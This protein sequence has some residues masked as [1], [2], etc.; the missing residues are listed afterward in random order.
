MKIIAIYLTISFA[1]GSF[2]FAQAPVANFSAD[3]TSG[4]SPFKVNFFDQ[5][6]GNPTSWQWD[7]GNGTI[8][9]KKDPSGVYLNPGT[10]QVK[11]TVTN[12]SGSSSKTGSITVYENPKAKFTADKKIGCAPLTVQFTDLSEA[13]NNSTNSKWMWDFGNGVQSELQNP[14]VKYTSTGTFTVVLKVTND[15]GC[16]NVF[17]EEKLIQVNQGVTLG[18]TNS[19]VATCQPPFNIQFTNS[20]TGAGT[21]NYTWKFGDGT[22][23]PDISPLHTYTAVGNYSVSLIGINNSGCTDT[24]TKEIKLAESNTDFTVSDTLCVNNAIFFTNNSSPAPTSSLWK[25]PDGTTATSVNAQKIFTDA[26]MYTIK[27]S[28][29]YSGCVGIK[30]KT[31]IVEEAPKAFFTASSLGK[32]SPDLTVTFDNLSTNAVKYSW[33]FGDGSAPEIT[34]SKTVSHTYTSLGF[35]KVTLTAFNNS[36]CSNTYILPD[37]IVIGP[38]IA[39]ITNVPEQACAP[40]GINPAA[41]ISS[42][43]INS[44]QWNFG[45]GTI[46][47]EKSPSHNYT[48]AGNYTITVSATTNDGC[49]VTDTTTI[50]VGNHSTLAFTANPRNVCAI[51]SVYFTNQSQPENALFTWY[52]G[53]GGTSQK[54]S[55]VYTYNDTGWFQVKL[56]ANNNGCLDS[57]YSEEK[58]IYIKAPIARFSYTP[59][60]NISYQYQFKDESLFDIG[61]EGNRTWKWVFPDGSIS[62]NPVPPVYTFPGPGE[63]T[64]SLT[65]SNGNCIHTKKQ[66]IRIVNKAADFSY[67]TNKKCK[68]VDLSFTAISENLAN[69]ESFRWEINGFD[70]TT[71]TPVFTHLFSDAG[72]YD[73]KLTTTDVTGCVDS[74]RKPV[75][76]S[77][78]EAAFSRTHLDDCTK[79]T[80]T[81]TDESKSFGANKI[82]SWKWDFGD[83]KSIERTNADTIK[84]TYDAPGEYL[85]KLLIRD[86]TGCMDTVQSTDPVIIKELSADWSAD[87]KACL[88]FPISFKNTSVGEFTSA[89]W[90]F[91][92][93]SPGTSTPEG[94]HTYTD[95]GRYDLKLVIQNEMGCKDSLVRKQ[96]V[97]IAKPLAAFSV[98]DSISFCPPFDVAFTNTSDFFKEV[99]WEIGTE[100][101]NEINH[102]KLFTQPGEYEVMLTVKSPDNNCTATASKTIKV[103]RSEDALI[104]YDPEQACLPGLVNFSAF[105]KLASARFFWDFGD[106]NILD[107]AANKITHLY[108]DLGSFTPK[109]ILTE[110]NGCVITIAGIKPIL[111]KGAKAKFSVSNQFFCDS[112]YVSIA[113]STTY[114]EPIA[115]YTWNFGDGTTSNLQTPPPH[116]FDRPGNYAVNLTVETTSGCKDTAQLETP[117]KLVNS[118]RIGIAGDS[119]I[120]VN[121]KIRHTGTLLEEDPSVEWFW[122]FPNGKNEKAQKPPVQ[123]YKEAGNFIVKTIAV[124]GSGCADTATKKIYV[125]PN[126]KATLPSSVSTTVGTPVL[127]PGKYTPQPVSYIWS[128]DSSLSCNN[129]PQPMA[130]PRFDTKYTVTIVDSNGCKHTENIQVN[131]LCEGVTVFLPNTFSPNGDG[132][133]DIFYVRGRG[134]DRVKSLRI[135]NRWGQ[136]VFEQKD[137]PVN[138][139]QHGWNGKMQGRKPHPDVY[140]YQVEVYCDNGELIN[141]A[142]NVALIQ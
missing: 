104:A 89:N 67:D 87:E 7:L 64:I 79:L 107:T 141:L 66:K 115:R 138:S 106:G 26:G 24:I 88:G 29:T 22:S 95:T 16:T 126:P 54:S 32:C 71:K 40:V 3:V 139:I 12:S 77:G 6:T 130:S 59:N 131:V 142:G 42:N 50:A 113:D 116:L 108:T 93:R 56:V 121:D 65:I 5:S 82:V 72:T 49:S 134:L 117:V 21:I 31:I 28:N 70:T 11:L 75:L 4:C 97:R 39:K 120:C 8:S 122:N 114:N 33:D 101:S 2:S 90:D 125:H 53:D 60:C 140:V 10:Y 94:T 37:S 86:A 111:I 45:D 98:K 62:T 44:Y 127:L 100:T 47:T 48:V 118:P 9:T 20:S 61:S 38:P 136:I 41:E 58:Y 135:F 81:F 102:R 78:S 84:H 14:V 18:F 73:L 123:Q 132:N 19:A 119:V 128:P 15:K 69:V 46:K 25:F 36:N 91:G 80:A 96:Y 109:I 35:F 137:F 76:I 105:D 133:N 17:T 55:P 112:G 30:E 52:F 99:E 103:Q 124:N 129:C 1:L 85:V 27:L 51:D 34:S 43:N 110:A 57:I 92:D 23:S 13:G 68:P 74:V 83:G 63:Y